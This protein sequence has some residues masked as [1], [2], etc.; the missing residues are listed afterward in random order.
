MPETEVA[1]T[2]D[3]GGTTPATE[4]TPVERPDWVPEAFWDAEAGEVAKS[5]RPFVDLRSKKVKVDSLIK[6]H[7]DTKSAYDRDRQAR[8]PPKDGYKFNVPDGGGEFDAEH[9]VAKSIVEAAAKHGISQAML[10]DIVAAYYGG[11]AA[12]PEY[13]R[14][15][16]GP[17]A[18]QKL[19][20]LQ[21]KIAAVAGD[22]ATMKR[23]L[24][25]MAF[26]AENVSALERLLAK[27][28]IAVPGGAAG[29]GGTSLATEDELRRVMATKEY[30]SGDPDV[31]R[32]VQEGW[33][34]LYPE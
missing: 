29:G 18:E 4:T 2:V 16:L 12:S 11:V 24:S 7:L 17:G 25:A 21:E 10:D 14:A 1:Q 32:R 8:T 27:P 9:P 33:Q 22:D 6:A 26:S 23:M 3:A 31:R 28:V 13:E 20:A 15:K 30:L 19:V 34:R 5:A